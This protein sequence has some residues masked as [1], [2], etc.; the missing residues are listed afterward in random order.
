[1]AWVTEQAVDVDLWRVARLDPAS[2]AEPAARFASSTRD[3]ISPQFS[4]DGKKVAFLSDRS[5][6]SEVWVCSSQGESPF[7]V[8]SFEGRGLVGTPR[9]SPDGSEIAF[10]STREGSRDIYVVSAEGGEAR[11]IT[12]EP[13]QD[14]RPS[15]SW[16]GKW[17]YFGSN[18]SGEWQLWKASPSGGVAVQ[19]TRRGGREAF[20]SRDGRFV[21][22]TK[23][24]RLAGIWKIPADGVE[25]TRVLDR[26]TQSYWAVGKEGLFYIDFDFNPRRIQFFSFQNG[27]LSLVMEIPKGIR[28]TADPSLAVSPDGRWILYAGFSRL[29]SDILLAENFR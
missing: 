28:F 27:R 22:Y 5:G 10:D 13:S 16:D 14:V 17:I 26:G 19:V 11:R 12:T 24:P 8:T 4:P 15:W 18:R 7:Q 29:E 25:E 20:E 2:K 6:N 3:E 9:W 21:Y 1:M 23:Q